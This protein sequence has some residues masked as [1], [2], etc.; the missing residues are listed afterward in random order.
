M[1]FRVNGANRQTCLSGCL[2][3]RERAGH[4]FCQAFLSVKKSGE[5]RG[6]A[7]DLLRSLCSLDGLDHH[8][9]NL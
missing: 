5:K 4:F 8:R 1:A 7:G 9:Y 2:R 6:K 3:S